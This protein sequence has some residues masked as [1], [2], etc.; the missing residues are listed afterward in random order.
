MT[1]TTLL[2]LSLISPQTLAFAPSQDVH[3]GVEPTR[4]MPVHAAHQYRLRKGETWQAFLQGDGAG[5]QVRF[6]ERTGTAHRAWGP[7]IPM[8]DL[9]SEQAVETS[10]RRFMDNNPALIGVPQSDLKTTHLGYIPATDTWYVQFQRT[11]KGIEVRYGGVTARIRHGKLILLGV[12]TY[13]Q[14]TGLGTRPEINAKLAEK[15]ARSLGP[16]PDAKHQEVSSKLVLLPQEGH[17][18]LGF[19][20]TWEVRSTTT[21]P[22][23]QWVSHIDAFSGKLLNVY[24]EVRFA[25]GSQRD[26]HGQG[27]IFGTHDERTVDGTT[28]TSPVPFTRVHDGQQAVYTDANGLYTYSGDSDTLTT[29]FIG[30]HIRVYNEQDSDGSQTFSHG[31][32]TWTQDD[33]DFDIAEL[34][35]YIFLNQVRD[36]GLDYA[37]DVEMVTADLISHV[38]LE[39]SCNAYYDGAVNFYRESN[40]CNATGRIADVNYH[41]WGHGFHYYSLE[42]GTWDGSLSEGLADSVA[43][44]LTGDN[45]ISPYFMKNGSGIRNVA[46]DRRYPEDWEGEVHADGLI[47]AGAV[48]DLWEILREDRDD[49]EAYDKTVNLFVNAIKGGPTIPDSFDEFIAADDNDGNLGNGTPNQCQII[50][51][52]QRHGL[53][54]MGSESLLQLN[55]TPLGNQIEGDPL[56]LRAEV[57]NL[58]EECVDTTIDSGFVHFSTD[59]GKTW[60][61]QV[62]VLSESTSATA[63]LTGEL[64]GFESGTIVHYYIEAISSD[65]QS[66]SLPRGASINPHSFYVGELIEMYCENF[67][68]S[69]GGGYTHELVA[70]RDDEGADDWQWGASAGKAGDP[71][72]AYSGQKLWANDLGWD[73]YNGEYQNNKHNRLLS[74]PI[75]VSEANGEELILQFRR[76]LT[77]EDGF[78]DKARVHVDGEAVW[79][80]HNSNKDDAEEHHIDETWALHTNSIYDVDGDGTIQIAWELE[81]D[82]GLTMGGWNVD[83][84]CVYRISSLPDPDPDPDPDPLDTGVDGDFG[85]IGLE[86]NGICACSSSPTSP[87]SGIMALLMG[88]VV[89][90]RRRQK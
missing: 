60:K 72:Q 74:V 45:I 46:P 69:D 32:F 68:N 85:E 48:W 77:I 66:Q 10:M 27:A 76:W 61:K 28:T 63:E 3:I 64:D 24:N 42:A 33:H 71:S 84:V 23:G 88:L 15:S 12:D 41:E 59:Q 65:G 55:H 26:G 11:E 73:N 40:Q 89:G 70:G 47:F 21:Q 75:D 5:W 17:Y 43:F 2:A 14:A 4:L 20:L 29:D 81:T 6:D 90:F 22:V 9:S 7:G 36:W 58:A 1:P 39:S 30:D 86:A 56:V 31:E 37:P 57:L 13:P 34:D 25:Q 50:E 53:G 8:E 19:H 62:L 51:A 67:E 44:F 83:D 80:N 82:Q 54:P 52:F 79:S 49:S 78:F 35:S 87:Q 38:N 16:A 18:G